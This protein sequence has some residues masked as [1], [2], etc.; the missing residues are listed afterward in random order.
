[1][2]RSTDD[3]LTKLNGSSLNVGQIHL[4]SFYVESLFTNVPLREVI[5]LA[6]KYIGLY[7]SNDKPCNYRV[8][9]EKLQEYTTSSLWAA[10]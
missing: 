6:S 7:Q 8:H 2:L 9:F 5:K 3:F 4:V 1:M 10:H